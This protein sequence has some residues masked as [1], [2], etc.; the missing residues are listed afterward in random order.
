MER[1]RSRFRPRPPT[2]V[3][4]E[5]EAWAIVGVMLLVL[6]VVLFAIVVLLMVISYTGWRTTPLPPTEPDPFQHHHPILS[7][8]KYRTRQLA[9]PPIPPVQLAPR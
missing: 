2:D 7:Q 3:A 5:Q 8:D 1:R 9:A 4:K 6:L